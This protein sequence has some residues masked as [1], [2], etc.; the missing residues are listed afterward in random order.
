VILRK[1][2]KVISMP[3]ISDSQELE[4]ILPAL[5]SH[6]VDAV[7]IG[8]WSSAYSEQELCVVNPKAI[9]RGSGESY[10]VFQKKPFSNPTDAEIAAAYDQAVNPPSS[11]S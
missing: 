2:A 1:F 3:D 7:K 9:I 8:D 4:D 11:A 5:W 6:G 10:A